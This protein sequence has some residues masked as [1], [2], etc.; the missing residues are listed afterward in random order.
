MD[1]EVGKAGAAETPASFMAE[2]VTEHVTALMM[3]GGIESIGSTK[4]VS[5]YGSRLHVTMAPFADAPDEVKAQGV[6]IKDALA[7]ILSV[8]N[9]SRVVMKPSDKER[10]K[11]KS[12]WD[13]AVRDARAA[14]G[15][16]AQDFSQGS[17]QDS[18]V[19]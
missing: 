7:A 1:V 19:Q 10:A 3:L 2:Y 18:K 12:T 16:S 13:Q 15:G 8:A 4:Y 14:N 11:F 5:G 9:I 6:V 17:G